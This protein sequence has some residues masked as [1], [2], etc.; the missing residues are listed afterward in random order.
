MRFNFL[1]NVYA[2]YII[3]GYRYNVIHQISR[4]YSFSLTETLC[5]LISN[6]PCPHPPVLFHTVILL[7]S[8]FQI[9]HIS[10]IMPYFS[11][12][13]ELISLHIVS[14][15]FIS[16]TVCLRSSSFLRSS[17]DAG[18]GVK[19]RELSHTVGRNENWSSCYGEQC[20]GSLR[21]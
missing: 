16:V 21:Y 19:K 5:P 13:E 14:S 11:F 6:F 9:P 3:V 15:R 18:K 17:V 20:G 10:V 4:M 12:C 8:L 1:K 2:Q 7:T